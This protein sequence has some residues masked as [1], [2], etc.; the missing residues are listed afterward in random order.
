MPSTKKRLTYFVIAMLLPLTIFAQTKKKL[1]GLSILAS[2][3]VQYYS[4]LKPYTFEKEFT[5]QSDDVLLKY[6]TSN[7]G[8]FTV[9]AGKPVVI[10]SKFTSKMPSQLINIGC[11]IQFKNNENIFNELSLTRL[12]FMKADRNRIYTGTDSLGK[13]IRYHAEGGKESMFVLGLRYE[14]GKYFGR[15]KNAVVRF[16]ISGSI[17]PS[18]FRFKYDNYS[19]YDYPL[20]AKLVTIDIALIPMLAINVSKSISLDFKAI[21]NF[22]TADFG[23]I[24]QNDPYIPNSK[25][26]GTRIYKSPDMTFA[27]S[28]QLRYMVRAAKKKRN[29]D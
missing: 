5:L 19:I 3:S 13:I 9:E 29:K 18:F 4:P 23:T 20:D 27:F 8:T 6:I 21:P 2:T 25:Q 10:T 14:L 22:L 1:K 26:G 15:N 11:S 16:G 24:R 17:E 12:A 7:S 28:V